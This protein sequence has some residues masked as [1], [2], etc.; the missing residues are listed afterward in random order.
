MPKILLPFLLLPLF[1]FAQNEQ[2]IEKKLLQLF[3]KIEDSRL[4]DNKN[5]PYDSLAIYK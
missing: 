3:V 5:F 2:A 1:S 4:S